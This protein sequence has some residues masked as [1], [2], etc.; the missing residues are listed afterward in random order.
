MIDFSSKQKEI[1]R[2]TVQQHHRWNISCGATRSGKTYL[3]YYRIPYRI[4]HA[5]RKG[6]IVLIGNTQSTIERNVLAPMREMWSSDLVTNVSRGENTAIL[7]GR[8]CYVLGADKANQVAKLQGMGISYAYGDEITTWSESV[9][10]ML[11]SRLDKP[12]S[13][14]DGTCNPDSPYHWFKG[15]LDNKDLDIYQ[16]QFQ[17]DDNPF[18]TQ[19]FIDNLKKEYAGT[20]YYNRFVLGQWA[21]AEGLVHPQFANEPQKYAVDYKD[22][23]SENGDNIMDIWQIYIGLDIGGTKSH[24]SLVA[25]GFTKRFGKQIRLGYKKIKHSKGTVDPDKI[26]TETEAFVKEI[27]DLY[28]GIPVVAIFVDNA[29]QVIE[30]GLAKYMAKSGMGLAVKDCKKVPFNDRVRA[31]TYVF[32]TGRFLWVRG[33]CND[34]AESLSTMVY[35]NDEKLLDNFTTDVDTYDADFYSWSHFIDYFSA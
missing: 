8:K 24:S 33:M 34:V 2:N 17:L 29:E 32:N 5:G 6:A 20:V 11:K 25:T 10:Q 18:L 27:R 15:F 4:R 31:Y 14:F 9:F 16:M 21:L 12:T 30:N 3:D 1:W 19:D 13:C 28:P 22:I 7:F 23:I 26:Y 35:G